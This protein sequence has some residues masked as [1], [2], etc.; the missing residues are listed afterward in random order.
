VDNFDGTSGDRLAGSSPDSGN[1]P[2]SGFD[3]P[4]SGSGRAGSC[5]SPLLLALGEGDGNG[6]SSALTFAK[7]A[8]RTNEIIIFHFMPESIFGHLAGFIG[9]PQGADRH[10]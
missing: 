2:V 4:G 7:P 1:K 5:I 6:E 9:R 3:C 10:T 8:A